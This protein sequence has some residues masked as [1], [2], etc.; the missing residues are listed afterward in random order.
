LSEHKIEAGK[1]LIR[2]LAELGRALG[3]HVE[4]EFPVEQ[5]RR[6]V[7]PAVDVAWFT[8]K[9]QVFPLFIF[10]VESRAS[11]SMANN[12]L[13]VFAQET[14]RFEKPLFFF[15]VIGSH[16]GESSRVGNLERQYGTYNYRI[17]IIG[18]NMGNELI[19]DILGQHRRIRNGIDY[20]GFYKVLST[21][22]RENVDI[23][24]ALRDAFDAGLSRESRLPA[25]V[26]LALSDGQV[27][28]ELRSALP[29]EAQKKW[30]ST[31][32]LPSYLGSSWGIPILCSMMILWADNDAEIQHWNE[33][34][35]RWQESSSYMPMITA[36]FGLSW[37]YDQFLIGVAAP[38]I[39]LCCALTGDKGS[40]R[41]S[42]CDVLV[43]ILSKL[44]GSWYALHTACWLAHISARFGMEQHFRAAMD[45]I[46]E[47]GGVEQRTLYCPPSTISTE[48][49]EDE[50]FPI[51][52]KSLCPELSEFRAKAQCVIHSTDPERVALNALTNDSYLYEWAG[53]L[54]GILWNIREH[55]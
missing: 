8:E 11:N 9:G 12:P 32:A 10:E 42:F 26:H 2:G 51:D 54:V 50:A 24:Q 49:A 55:G 19:K 16:G 15:Q 14:K 43:D 38:L 34:L 41:E 31:D 6:G 33:E 1:Q 29:S 44:R 7:P 21:E 28:R 47:L 3:Y 4:K 46:N 22:W 17:Y 45:S 25:Y 53:D 23:Y 48:I 20:V 39:A 30:P 36:S 5:P 35:L 37:D 40:F 52:C 27:V 18:E 13:K